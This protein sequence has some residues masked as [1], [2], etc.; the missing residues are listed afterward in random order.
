MEPGAL[1][2]SRKTSLRLNVGTSKAN[3]DY[4]D[5]YLVD[6]IGIHVRMVYVPTFAW[7]LW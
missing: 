5:I 2:S 3:F 1:G 6:P 7:L 4:I